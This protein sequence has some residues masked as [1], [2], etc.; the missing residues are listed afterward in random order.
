M[1]FLGGSVAYVEQPMLCPY[2]T[3]TGVDRR[4]TVLTRKATGTSSRLNTACVQVEVTSC[5]VAVL[6]CDLGCVVL[7]QKSNLQT[8]KGH[9]PSRCPLNVFP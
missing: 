3:S 8:R 7:A 9:A 1:A 2:W 5:T 4:C 6:A